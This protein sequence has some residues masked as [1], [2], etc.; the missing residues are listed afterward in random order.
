MAGWLG[1]LALGAYTIMLNVS[2]NV[3]VLASGVG[4][5][6]AVLMGIAKGKNPFWK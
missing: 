5:A 2:T 3:F 6:S 1:A 4:T